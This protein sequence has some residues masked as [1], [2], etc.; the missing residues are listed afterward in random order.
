MTESTLEEFEKLMRKERLG[1]KMEED[2]KRSPGDMIENLQHTKY[3]ANINV[4]DIRSVGTTT[5]HYRKP[6]AKKSGQKKMGHSAINDV[7]T[8][9]YTINIHKCIHG[10]GLKNY[11]PSALKEIQKFATKEI[12]TPDVHIDTRLNKAVWDKGIGNVPYQIHVQ[13]FRKC[14]EDEDSPKKLYTL[15]IYVPVTSFKNLQTVDVAEN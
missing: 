3:C 1:Q 15:I 14:H 4:A 10:V 5:C 13:L 8:Q 6:P 11:T 12:G 9:E 7:V 2:G